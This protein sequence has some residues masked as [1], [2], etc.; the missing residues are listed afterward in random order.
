MGRL[1][2]RYERPILRFCRHNKAHL[3]PIGNQK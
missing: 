1:K 2:K 3:I